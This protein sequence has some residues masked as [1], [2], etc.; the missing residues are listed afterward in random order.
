MDFVLTHGA[1]V[2]EHRLNRRGGHA[3][4]LGFGSGACR[5]AVRAMLVRLK[6]PSL[7]WS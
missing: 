6:C 7:I 4:A 3:D 1:E 2:I 5:R